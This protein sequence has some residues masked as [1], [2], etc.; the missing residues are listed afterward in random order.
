MTYEIELEDRGQDLIRLTVNENTGVIEDA[1]LLSNIFAKGDCVVDTG[2]LT[3][4]RMVEYSR[5]GDDYKT[6]KYPMTKLTLNGV[7]LCDVN[8]AD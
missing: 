6:F 7:V 4:S 2:S 5:A 1:G 8:L 3:D